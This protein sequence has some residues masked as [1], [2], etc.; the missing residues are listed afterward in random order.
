MKSADYALALY[1]LL[2]CLEL[3]FD[4][5]NDYCMNTIHHCLRS[6]LDGVIDEEEGNRIF[7][8]NASF[9]GRRL[10]YGKPFDMDSDSLD[11]LCAS[12][13]AARDLFEEDEYSRVRLKPRGY[14]A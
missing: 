6:D 12:I 10:A 4:H 11:Q 8:R 1:R 13:K 2:S 9:V 5:D 3:V 14:Q 7:L